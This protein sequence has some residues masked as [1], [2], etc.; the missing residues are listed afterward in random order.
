MLYVHI[1]EK[2]FTLTCIFVLYLFITLKNI[3]L[4]VKVINYKINL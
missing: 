3:S 4:K 1:F 2:T